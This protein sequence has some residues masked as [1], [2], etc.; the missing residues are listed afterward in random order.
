MGEAATGQGD[1]YCGNCGYALTGATES[2]KCP[3]CGQPLVEV[4]M[5][6]TLDMPGGKRF[7]SKGRIFGMPIVDVAIGPSGRERTGKARGFV[8]IGNEA[9]GVLAIGGQA[10]GVVAIGGMAVGGF[11]MGGLSI[12]LLSALGG[13][14]I[15][16]VALGGWAM[17]GLARGGGAMGFVADGGM[18]IGVYARGGGAVGPHTISPAGSSPEAAGVFD[19]LSWL[20]GPWP[21][22]VWSFGTSFVS[23]FLVT[24]GLAAVIAIVAFRAYVEEGSSKGGAA[25]P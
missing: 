1:P 10:V 9:R 12:G 24:A 13:M 16:G 11:T 2:S 22:S 3:E 14:A 23:M 4:L 7:R 17:G 6:P 25:P 21:P 5:R 18:A 19:A 20:F 15:G 8:A